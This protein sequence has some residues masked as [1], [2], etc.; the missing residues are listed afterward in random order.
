MTTFMGKF[1]LELNY[2]ATL[3]SG[4]TQIGP[5]ASHSPND[6]SGQ[7]QRSIHGTDMLTGKKVVGQ[8]AM[9]VRVEQGTI[10]SCSTTTSLEGTSLAE[11]CLDGMEGL[12][13]IE[14]PRLL[15]LDV[16]ESYARERAVFASPQ[17]G[18]R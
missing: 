3:D 7:E 13:M 8:R 10:R 5:V 18:P 9:E 15:A 12:N 16:L 1:V 14:R 11:G 17:A 4:T 6:V 2:P